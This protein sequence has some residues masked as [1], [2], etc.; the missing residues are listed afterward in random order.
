VTKSAG[1]HP[2]ICLGIKTGSV[3]K[4]SRQLPAA[5]SL[6]HHLVVE[7]KPASSRRQLCTDEPQLL[8]V[9]LQRP[10]QITHEKEMEKTGAYS[11]H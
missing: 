5:E 3:A 10:E 6:C 4:M 1:V 11:A 7:H 2:N 8:V 9:V